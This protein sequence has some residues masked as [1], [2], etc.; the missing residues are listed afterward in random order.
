MHFRLVWHL[1]GRYLVTR[2]LLIIVELVSFLLIQ[3]LVTH[4][5]LSIDFVVAIGCL[6]LGQVVCIFLVLSLIRLLPTGSTNP[7]DTFLAPIF[8]FASAVKGTMLLERLLPLVVQ[9]I[10][11]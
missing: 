10:L 8:L 1:M 6:R 9:G 3:L 4:I 11:A 2:L 7:P 5:D